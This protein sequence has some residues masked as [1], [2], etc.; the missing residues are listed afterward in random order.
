MR[1]QRLA[2]MMT[3][4]EIATV[5]SGCIFCFRASSEGSYRRIGIAPQE[6]LQESAAKFFHGPGTRP[7]KIAGRHA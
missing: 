7:K 4:T 1:T 2:S 5:D 6:N 3:I